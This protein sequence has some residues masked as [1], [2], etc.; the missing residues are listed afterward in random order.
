M[1]LLHTIVQAV[2]V[3]SITAAA[4][5]VFALWVTRNHRYDDRRPDLDELDRC[6]DRHPSKGDVARLEQMLAIRGAEDAWDR[7]DWGQR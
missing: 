5:M 6:I 4:L 3:L 7:D 2:M 1:N